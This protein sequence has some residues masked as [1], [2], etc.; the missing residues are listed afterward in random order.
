LGVL[1]GLVAAAVM[2]CAAGARRTASAHDRFRAAQRAFD[3][4]VWSPCRSAPGGLDPSIAPRSGCHHELAQLPAVDAAATVGILDARIETLDGR[5]VQPDP[6]DACYSDQ[7]AVGLLSA[8]SGSFGRSLDRRR[9]VAGRDADPAAADEVVL[10]E[11]TAARLRL[12]PGDRLVVRLYGD[13]GCADDP[14]S[15]GPRVV[16][17][18][19]GVELS[20]GEVRPPSGF[21]LQSVEVTPAFVRVTSAPFRP[22]LA[23][24][25]RPDATIADFRRQAMQI[26]A[27]VQ[28]AA[29]ATANAAAVEDA[30][31]PTATALG[32]LAA[33]VAIAGVAI[34]GPVLR[35]QAEIDAADDATLVALGAGRR[36][37]IG[38]S[39]LRGCSIAVIA[40]GVALVAGVALSL[41]MPI[42][43]ARTVELHRGVAVDWSV[44]GVGIVL[45]IG[46]IVVVTVFGAR[47]AASPRNASPAGVS[48]RLLVGA[49]RLSIPAA[50]G[51]R[52]ATRRRVGDAGVPV[53]SGFA[54]L[55]VALAAIVGAFTFA[56][57]LTHLRNTPALVGWNWDIAITLPQDPTFTPAVAAQSRGRVRRAFAHDA[58]V[59]GYSAGLIYAPFPLG[60]VLELGADHLEV[61]S[62]L[63]LDE[64]A[65]VAPS[66]IAGRAPRA[67]DEIALGAGTLAT[68]RAHLG[69]TVAAFGRAGTDEQPGGPTSSRMRIVG[70]VVIPN[71]DQLGHGAA[72]TL[73]GIARL[74]SSAAD[75]LYVIR[76]SNPSDIDAAVRT[77]RA[78]FSESPPESMEVVGDTGPSP[79]LQL[80]AIEATP[81]IFL[82]LTVAMG[83][84]VLAHLLIVGTRAQR[85]DLAVLRALGF[86]RSQVART[87]R[88]HAM[89]Y[90]LVAVTLGTP[91]G[92]AIGRSAWRIYARGLDVI[93]VAEIPLHGLALTAFGAFALAT[94]IA[95]PTGIQAAR[96][97]TAAVLRTE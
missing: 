17:R 72:L 14:A 87:A 79:L 34:F 12:G 22:Y 86:S 2:G 10:S 63:A 97:N 43:I 45:T 39:A 55:T 37:L 20:P 89:T 69:D 41:A 47:R 46:F 18:V 82:L 29:D 51:V 21:Y 48:R 4:A 66:V 90:A 13:Q 68:L 6:V 83:I 80:D 3:V 84:A 61:P 33:L 65:T 58:R 85:H 40:A 31:R 56:A 28:V 88:Y 53:V 54:S 25:L 70:T 62:L 94:I 19:V 60:S 15:W 35:R 7:G 11:A 23:V 96:M 93:P 73:S 76:L 36:D 16:V 77:F 75:Q 64:Q 32:I 44:F 8:G 1:I 50:V 71:A 38:L 92:I 49:S 57:S 78:A 67:D 91:L 5:S 59:V 42:G 24:R 26:G 30:I 9:F 52:L 81:W 27:P 74:N 95:V